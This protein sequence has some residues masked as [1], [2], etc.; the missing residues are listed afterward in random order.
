MTEQCYM[1][2]TSTINIPTVIIINAITTTLAKIGHLQICYMACL[3]YLSNLI[4]KSLD[5]SMSVIYTK[6]YN[7]HTLS[8]LF[9]T[10]WDC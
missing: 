10:K 3:H 8:L 9:H 5:K 7:T 1:N 2:N 4:N 6:L